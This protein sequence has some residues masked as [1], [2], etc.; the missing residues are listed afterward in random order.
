MWLNFDF[1]GLSG[2]SMRPLRILHVEDSEEDLILFGRA[3]EAAGLPTIFHTV[4]DGSQAVAYLKGEGEFHDRN[5]HPFP[6]LI[7]L[8][9]NLPGMDGFDFLG[10]LRREARLSLP[11]LVF[12]IS[13]SAEDKSKALAA[14]ASGYFVKPKDFETLV[15]LAESFRRFGGDGGDKKMT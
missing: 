2:G 15:R 9:L 8:D 3:C 14:G 4:E 7:I 5:Q 6:D 13:G 1:K 10:W 11:V 12:T